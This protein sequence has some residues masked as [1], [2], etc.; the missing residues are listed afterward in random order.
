M[1][2][3]KPEVVA[4]PPVKLAGLPNP[5]TIAELSALAI[6]TGRLVDADPILAIHRGQDGYIV[7]GRFVPDPENAGERKWQTV[8]VFRPDELSR[9]GFLPGLAPELATDSYFS[10]NGYWRTAPGLSAA[11]YPIASRKEANLRYLNAC[12]ADIDCGRPFDPDPNKRIPATLA[13]AIVLQ[14]AERGDIPYPSMLALSGRGLYSFWLLRDEKDPTKPPRSFNATRV[15]FYKAVNRGLHERLAGLLPVDRPA[16]DAARVLRTPGSINSKSGE[17]VNYT[18]L[19]VRNSR[20]PS[21][22]YT[23]GELADAVGV[24]YLTLEDEDR[25]A[26]GYKAPRS[27]NPN[28]RKGYRALAQYLASDIEAIFQFRP[29]ETGSRRRKL[30]IY[31][32]LLKQ[33]GKSHDVAMLSCSEL[34]NNCSPRYPD[35]PMGAPSPSVREIVTAAYKGKR[36]KLRPAYLANLFGVTHEVGLELGLRLIVPETVKAIR[37]NAE[38]LG[39]RKALRER[40]IRAIRSYLSTKST[41]SSS[42]VLR[43]LTLQGIKSNRETVNEDMNA[44]GYRR[45]PGSPGRPRKRP[46][47]GGSK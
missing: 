17:T 34:A 6:S 23:L 1:E 32:A 47:P 22:T 8:G 45:S 30:S 4:L 16:H 42:E 11:A 14:L 5:P 29:W 21:G 44:L 39:S 26:I 15:A 10:V 2:H 24:P 35:L 41:V 37:K 9:D 38:L 43:F 3:P 18:A 19:L 31:A 40:R 13:V 28:N 25:K 33:A 27:R 46:Y 12:F 7:F 36:V 20:N